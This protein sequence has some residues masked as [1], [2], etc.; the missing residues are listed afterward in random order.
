MSTHS[1]TTKIARVPRLYVETRLEGPDIALPSKQAHYLRHVLRLRSGN[2]VVV[3]NGRGNECLAE[4]ETL[5]R[6]GA[7]LRIT[8]TTAPIPEPELNLTL[9]QGIAKA[10]AMDLI[11]QKATELGVRSIAPVVTEFSVVK[12]DAQR[13][14]RR[15]EHW[16]RVAHSACEQSGRHSPPMICEPQPLERGLESLSQTGTR[17]VLDPTAELAFADGSSSGHCATPVYLLIGPE[18]GLSKRDLMLTDKAGFERVKLGPRILRVETA[19]IAAC[20]IAQANWGDLLE[21]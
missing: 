20:T 3:F 10:D 21:P 5:T 13:I 4:I 1:H 9:L 14:G 19:A 18:G 17:L 7:K 12:I 2:N 8:S 15:L 11:V 16:Q 6:D